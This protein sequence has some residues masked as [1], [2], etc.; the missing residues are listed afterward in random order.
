MVDH[1]LCRNI[2]STRF[3]TFFQHKKNRRA[4]SS[5]SNVQSYGHPRYDKVVCGCENGRSE[6]CSAGKF[7]FSIRL[8]V[9]VSGPILS[10]PPI[11]FAQKL[12]SGSVAGRGPPSAVATW[13][14]YGPPAPVVH[15]LITRGAPDRVVV[16]RGCRSPYAVHMPRARAGCLALPCLASRRARAGLGMH[17]MD[18]RLSRARESSARFE[19]H[20]WTRWGWGVVRQSP[21]TPSVR[22]SGFAHLRWAGRGT[23][24]AVP[25]VTGPRTSDFYFFYAAVGAPRALPASLPDRQRQAWPTGLSAP[26]VIHLR[27]SYSR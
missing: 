14:T 5:Y 9:F 2:V 1:Y 23:L 13:P 20:T 7:F 19:P 25:R 16:L 10:S 12:V 3:L 4:P 6:I 24:V 17:G 11:A 26:A 27:A 21:S 22:I 8:P 15:R 18:E